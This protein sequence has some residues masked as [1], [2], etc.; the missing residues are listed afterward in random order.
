MPVEQC[1]GYH[2]S[3]KG[4]Y[5]LTEVCFTYTHAQHNYDIKTTWHPKCRMRETV[6][7]G[8]SALS[9]H[10]PHFGA[11]I[12]VQVE[13]NLF[14][15]ECNWLAMHATNLTGI[16][17]PYKVL[18]GWIHSCNKA[19]V[20]LLDEPVTDKWCLIHILISESNTKPYLFS[21]EKF[22]FLCVAQK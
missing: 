12:N 1:E 5:Y 7:S 3:N 22:T 14:R 8:C 17:R 2:C 13:T 21:R 20:Q 6:L 9:V 16:L 18:Y 11:P 15:L 4:I 10:S 19:W